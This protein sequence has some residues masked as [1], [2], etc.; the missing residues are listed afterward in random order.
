[1]IFPKE[2]SGK[3]SSIYNGFICPKLLN[4]KHSI[5]GTINIDFIYCHNKEMRSLIENSGPAGFA[6]NA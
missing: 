4:A 5:T 3:E 2:I 6:G 1:M